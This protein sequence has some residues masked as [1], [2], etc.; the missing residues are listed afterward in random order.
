MHNKENA[1]IVLLS[2]LACG[3][4]TTTNTAPIEG[5]SC[6]Y[7]DYPGTCIYEEDGSVTFVGTISGEEVSFSRNDIYSV[8]EQGEPTIGTEIPCTIS[9]ITQGTCTPCLLDVGSCGTEAFGG[10]PQ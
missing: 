4:K 2:L 10:L 1:V 6:T 5:G 7:D 9:Y 8:P 3:P